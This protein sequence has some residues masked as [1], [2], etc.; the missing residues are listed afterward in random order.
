MQLRVLVTISED[1]VQLLNKLQLQT[2]TSIP[3]FLLMCILR[4]SLK[5]H[6]LCQTHYRQRCF[7]VLLPSIRSYCFRLIYFLL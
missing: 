7:L 4:M 1:L 5:Y 6:I 2:C 3:C